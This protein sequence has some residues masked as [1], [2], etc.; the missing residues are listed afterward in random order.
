MAA[1]T[2][3]G[4]GLGRQIERRFIDYVPENERRGRVSSG[5]ATWNRCAARYR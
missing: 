1:S 5:R 4:A 2:E 3:G